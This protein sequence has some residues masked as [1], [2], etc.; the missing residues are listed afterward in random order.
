MNIQR[1]S[2]LLIEL[3]D[4]HF[5]ISSGEFGIDVR[6]CTSSGEYPMQISR[7]QAAS[8]LKQVPEAEL[9]ALGEKFSTPPKKVRND[10]G[11]FK[12]GS[13]V[14]HKG[15]SSGAYIVARND[16]AVVTAVKIINIMNPDEWDVLSNP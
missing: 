15:S 16:G 1:K 5:L 14:R 11:K 6:Q 4:K 9:S 2:Q 3:D 13:L 7:E 8:V 12:L 10:F